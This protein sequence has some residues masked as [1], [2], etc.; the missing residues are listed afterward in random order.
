VTR[1]PRSAHLP[2]LPRHYRFPMR[3]IIR[4]L[5][6]RLRRFITKSWILSRCYYPLRGHHLSGRANDA[7]WY[8]AYGANMDDSTFR[9]RR[10]IQVLECRIG[11]VKGYRLRFNLDGRPKGKA[12]PANLHPDPEAE[13]WGVLYRITRRDLIRLDATEGVPGRGYR[14]VEVD[15]EDHHGRA[16]RAVT[17]IARGKEIDGKPSLR[18]IKLLREGARAYGLPETYTRFLDGVEHAQ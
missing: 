17:Y 4:R 13:V 5:R 2:L 8:F 1:G 10:G 6:P 9:I 14:H 11:H 3:Q 12:A 18:Y 15:V 7:I 16:I